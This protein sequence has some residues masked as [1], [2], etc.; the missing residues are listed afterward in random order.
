MNVI[1]IVSMH[2]QD[3]AFVVFF[4]LT[5]RVSNPIT[6][7]PPT[8]IEV[9]GGRFQGK[10][11]GRFHHGR[12]GSI[13]E[14]LTNV[15]INIIPDIS[16]CLGILVQFFFRHAQYLSSVLNSTCIRHI[17]RLLEFMP[18]VSCFLMFVRY[19]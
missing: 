11:G 8:E 16:E 6:L 1:R 17:F 3:T 12:C 19:P 4:P 9:P 10:G 2:I 5:W 7:V 18:V 13:L 14:S 15:G